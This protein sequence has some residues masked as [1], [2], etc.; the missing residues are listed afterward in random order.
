MQEYIKQELAKAS[1]WTLKKVMSKSQEVFY[2]NG[3]IDQHR[4]VEVIE[5]FITLYM[6]TEKEGT[7]Y[8]GQKSLTLTP[9]DT[10]QEVADKLQS[11]RE[12]ALVSVSP[13]FP[14]QEKIPAPKRHTNSF[15]R[16]PLKES[17]ESLGD[18]LKRTHTNDTSWI[19]SAEV[20]LT[21]HDVVWENSQGLELSYT[22]YKGFM[23]LV[24]TGKDQEEKEFEI[25]REIKFS[26]YEPENLQ[27][28]IDH[29]LDLIKDRTKAIPLKKELECPVILT[30]TSVRDFFSFY[31]N[32]A[33]GKIEYQNLNLFEVGEEL[34]GS[35]DK[36]TLKTEPYLYNSPYS[37]PV[38]SFG[39]PY[40]EVY[41]Y[42]GGKVIEKLYNQQYAYYSHK[43]VKALSP[44]FTVAPGTLSSD[45]LKGKPYLE[46]VHFSNFD[47]NMISG[48]FGG[49]IR[50]GYYYDGNR[51]IPISGGS[52]SGNI[53][54]AQ[55]SY[56][57]SVTM[58]TLENY[59]G[60]AYI[61][62]N[63]ISIAGVL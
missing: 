10:Q 51:R 18:I 41:L 40:H 36:L 23:D 38:D 22:Y 24:I 7:K 3:D 33:S 20:T 60:P 52:I 13:W 6:D 39:S 12:N 9:L 47:V 63:K 27:N 25:E 53:R 30:E 1:A 31:R 4:F 56:Q 21:Y 44:N 55:K 61:L 57:F 50:L 14:L 58:M 28:I 59:E 46:I 29:Q 43:P 15:D 35:G 49:E 34:N 42:K 37:E 48:S 11:A 8:R 32:Q 5:Y 17:I 45:E 54:E 2:I 62:L 19:N 16:F 26:D